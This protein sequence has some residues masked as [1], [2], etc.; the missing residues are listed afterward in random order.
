MSPACTKTR[1]FKWD[2]SNIGPTVGPPLQGKALTC[3]WCTPFLLND[4]GLISDLS[5]FMFSLC[6]LFLRDFWH[7]FALSPFVLMLLTI[8][9]VPT[10]TMMATTSTLGA[11]QSWL[12]WPQIVVLLRIVWRVNCN[13][14]QSQIKI[15]VVK[16]CENNQLL[17]RLLG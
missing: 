17:R 13:Q 15:S 16:N 12:S 7:L 3:F 14:K 6:Q 8:T 4:Q 1:P 5:L 9:R 11:P 2:F 10:T